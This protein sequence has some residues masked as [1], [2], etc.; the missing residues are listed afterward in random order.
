M[1]RSM[2]IVPRLMIYIYIYMYI[3][4]YIHKNL[5]RLYVLVY[6]FI[7]RCHM[8]IYNIYVYMLR[9]YRCILIVCYIIYHYYFFYHSIL[10]Q[11]YYILIVCCNTYVFLF[12]RRV[13]P[14][15]GPCGRFFRG[16]TVCRRFRS[17]ATQPNLGLV[18]CP[19][20]ALIPGNDHHGL[21][22]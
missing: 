18:P 16:I 12:K 1:P 6:V 21:R 3:Y 8:Y 17:D 4:I 11:H 19:W 14:T 22:L 9:V 13:L 7:D 20:G 5:H 15:P 2:Q 10:Y